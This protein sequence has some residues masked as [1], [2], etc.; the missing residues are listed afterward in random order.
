[1]SRDHLREASAAYAGVIA[2]AG[3]WRLVVAPR[4]AAYAVQEPEGDGWRRV[5][6]FETGSALSTWLAVVAIDPP[7]ALV[8]AAK[9]LPQAPRDCSAVP[10]SRKLARTGDADSNPQETPDRS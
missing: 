5:R 10:Y 6:A 8:G 9:R 4:G 2:E 3:G 7:A 1:M